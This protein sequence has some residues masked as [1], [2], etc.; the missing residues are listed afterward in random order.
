MKIVVFQ[1]IDSNW[2]WKIV[3]PGRYW[4]SI[5]IGSQSYTRKSDAKRG[6]ER[7]EAKLWGEYMKWDDSNGKLADGPPIVIEVLD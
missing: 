7:F 4:V 5:A 2:Y 1:N 3:N 6:A